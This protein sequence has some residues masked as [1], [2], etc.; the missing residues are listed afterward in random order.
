MRKQV[1]AKGTPQEWACYYLEGSSTFVIDK[2]LG[3]QL[4]KLWNER[5]KL[6]REFYRSQKLL[7]LNA[8]IEKLGK[9]NDQAIKIASIKYNKILARTQKGDKHG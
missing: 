1:V 3:E 7:E 8:K 2:E 9:K 6:L 5:D 4:E